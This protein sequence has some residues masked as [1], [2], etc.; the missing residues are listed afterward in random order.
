MAD[1]G[2]DKK[3]TPEEET[4]KLGAKDCVALI[5]AALETFLLP[6]LVLIGVIAVVA[7]F[8]VFRP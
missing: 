3:K 7:L 1:E 2:K 4:P 6:M 5:V 8:F